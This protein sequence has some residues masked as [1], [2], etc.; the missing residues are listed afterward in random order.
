MLRRLGTIAGLVLALG[1][2][3][4]ARAQAQNVNIVSRLGG[5]CLD[6][7]GGTARGKRVIG[8]PCNGGANQLFWFNQNGTITQG[9]WCLDASGGLGRDGDQIVLWDCN[10]QANQRWR[11]V[12]RSLVG[13]NG[14]C[15]DL[16]GGGWGNVPFLNQPAILYRC[17]GQDNQNWLAGIPLPASK[18]RASATVASG[19]QTPITPVSDATARAAIRT[20]GV[21]STGGGNVI[22]TGGG[23]VISTGG[24]NV[25]VPIAVGVISTGGGN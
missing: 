20:A 13:V 2:F 10:G 14:K 23:N 9:S 5:K 21:I 1:A 16:S 15:L 17:N 8:Y 24:G 3:A 4:A 11:L 18:V 22:S 12:G 6:V 25:I 7:E 19:Q